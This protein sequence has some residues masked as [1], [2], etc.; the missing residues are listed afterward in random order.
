MGLPSRLIET[1][2]LIGIITGMCPVD[3]FAGP[4][5]GP[6]D[7]ETIVREIR[8][9]PSLS[10]TPSLVP[11]FVNDSLLTVL[12]DQVSMDSLH[13]TIADLVA[14]GTRYE[15]TAEQESAAVYL[16]DR[17]TRF[18]YDPYYEPYELSEWDILDASW[19]PDG[20]EGW[21][22]L[23]EGLNAE[24]GAIVHTSDGGGS[25]TTDTFLPVPVGGICASD[26]Q[27]IWVVGDSGR[28]FQRAGGIWFAADTLGLSQLVAVDFADSL[29][30][31]IAS[32]SGSVFFTSDGG[33]NWIEESLTTSKLNDV[34]FIDTSNA[35]LCGTSG[36]IW[37][38]RPG[39]WETVTSGTHKTVYDLDFTDTSY[40]FAAISDS[41][42]LLWNGISWN[43]VHTGVR[44]GYTVKTQGDSTVWLAGL[45]YP[46]L[47]THL[48]RSNDRGLHWEEVEFP[49]GVLWRNINEIHF[50]PEENVFLGGY[51][52]LLMKSGDGGVSWSM[53]A[54]SPETS[55]PSR[56]VAAER[57]GD[58]YPDSIVILSAHYDSYAEMMQYDPMESAPGADDDASGVAAVL[59][60]AR[61][62]TDVRTE[63]TVRFVL[64]SGE[65]LG[66]LG[67]TAYAIDRAKEGEAIQAVV[68]VDMIGI[69][70]EPLGVYSD[71]PSTWILDRAGYAADVVAPGL[72]C[73]L[74]VQPC[75]TYS[76]HASFWK[77]GFHAV[78]ISEMFDE[79][80]PLHTPGDTLGNIDFHFARQAT[81]VITALTADLA[82]AYRMPADTDS[83]T[84]LFPRPNP[85]SGTVHIPFAFPP[86][87]MV[88]AVIYDVSGRFIRKLGFS[89]MTVEEGTGWIHWDGKAMNGRTVAP[90]VYIV[91]IE[92][93]ERVTK[94]KIV[95]V[96]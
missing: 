59:E 41:S 45:G 58:V 39:G 70:G 67:S 26:P 87:G 78:L 81:R 32:R 63:C 68:Q 36:K 35:W 38:W 42:A 93:G 9:A 43:P 82:G 96:R 29:H 66:L 3:I 6:P 89:E 49:F 46:V 17:F 8:N 53:P 62:F 83:I 80:N 88:F 73:S 40:G 55:H 5:A 4:P 61:I 20:E 94:M 27:N 13:R 31:L 64:F 22:V 71:E 85:S 84:A 12:A 90:G 2:L 52:G 33:K 56:N 51:D 48:I 74:L 91:R 18:G 57:I 10:F 92:S 75:H 21:A 65:E 95:V 1:L 54:L 86:S 11:S 7:R 69:P 19:L 25:W 47:L 15:Y 50:G 16:F 24:R 30:G 34:V 14:F 77:S 44:F 23:T 79:D 28:V 60:A 76:D 72:P 37:R